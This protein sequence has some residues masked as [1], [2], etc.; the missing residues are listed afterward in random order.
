MQNFVERVQI[1]FVKVTACGAACMA[2]DSFSSRSFG[3]PNNS[4]NLAQSSHRQAQPKVSPV[5]LPALQNASRVLL[6][7]FSKDL[8]I[9]PDLGETLTSCT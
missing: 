3:G 8:Q 7:Q 5:D 4:N 6:N 2:S 9:I 1:V